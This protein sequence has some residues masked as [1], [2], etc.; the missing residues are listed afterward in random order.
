MKNKKRSLAL[1][2]ALVLTIVMIFP[3]T[4]VSADAP[5]PNVFTALGDSTGFGLSAYTTPDRHPLFVNGFNDQFAESLDLNKG[6]DY[7]NV[8]MPGDRTYEL[9]TK[10]NTPEFQIL[11]GQ[12]TIM[13]V[14]IGGNNLLGPT[15]NSICALWGVLPQV[16]DPTGNK[17]LALLAQAV[18]LKYQDNP[19]YDPFTEFMR[20]MNPED[21]VA[22][23]FHTA[24][25]AGV[26]D[27]A[28]EWPQ[29]AS[30]IRSLNQNAELYVN[31]VH[32]PLRVNGESDPLYPLY[33]EFETLIRKINKNI[34]AYARKYR[35]QVVD[36]NKAFKQDP[37][38][39]SF[40]ILGAIA[41][42]T[43]LAADPYNPALILAFLQKTDPH[44]TLAGHVIAF[45]LLTKVRRITPGQYW[46]R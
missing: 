16:E 7:F 44:P 43:A 22:Q 21:P 18:V 35:Y 45:E 17:M 25:I 33:L 4:G 41:T 2:L 24:L 46:I 34:K 6:L 37:A 30:K 36:I 3:F 9:L 19:Y 23:Y 10:L 1:F 29:I 26:G 32:N 14:T 13:T 12:S 11:V 20:L 15:I 27:F 5:I 31:T 8:A 38:S 28:Q 42:A 39:L 40:D